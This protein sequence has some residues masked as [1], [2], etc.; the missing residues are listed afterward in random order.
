MSMA[1]FLVGCATQPEQVPMEPVLT[2]KST[3]FDE[4]CASLA[5]YARAVSIMR[6][7]GVKVED[8]DFILP[9]AP[10]VPTGTVQR[11]IYNRAENNP[12]TTARTIYEECTAMGY[13]TIMRRFRIEEAA[14]NFDEKQKALANL[15]KAKG[16]KMDT[17]PSKPTKPKKKVIK[18]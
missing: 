12:G 1:L 8:V 15:D 4:S 3:V 7:F 11:Y 14:Y 2:Y 17:D 18:K 13:D 6:D 5:K 10:N 16:M 9:Y